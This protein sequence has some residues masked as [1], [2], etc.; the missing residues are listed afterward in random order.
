MFWAVQANKQTILNGADP[1][2]VLASVPDARCK[3][4]RLKLG[5]KTAID[6][7][8]LVE[9]TE[10]GPQMASDVMNLKPQEIFELVEDELV[11]KTREQVNVIKKCKGNIC[12]EQVLA[13]R[14]AAE[15]ADNLASLTDL[16]SLPILIKFFG[17]R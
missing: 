9:D 10:I 16:V 11:G 3:A 12:R 14:H 13:H 5:G 4:W 1:V 17:L 2:E 7:T 6:P 15:G 8:T